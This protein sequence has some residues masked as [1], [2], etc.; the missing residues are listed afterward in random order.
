MEKTLRTGSGCSISVVKGGKF[1]PT[2]AVAKQATKK[3][4]QP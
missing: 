4:S 2:K 1:K 3:V